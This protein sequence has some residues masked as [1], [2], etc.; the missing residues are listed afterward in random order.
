MV[1]LGLGQL[2]D[3]LP[4][5]R[6]Q[7]TGFSETFW[8][9]DASVQTYTYQNL[10]DRS[11]CE[12]AGIVS[13]AALWIHS[14]VQDGTLGSFAFERSTRPHIGPHVSVPAVAMNKCDQTE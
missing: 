2:L 5:G 9:E 1:T 10:H 12:W 13:I 14:V 7:L 4:V 3:K 11:N 6:K 8:F